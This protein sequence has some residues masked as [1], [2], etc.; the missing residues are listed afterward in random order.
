MSHYH[1]LHYKH[2]CITYIN[3]VISIVLVPLPLYFGNG[4]LNV[5]VKSQ[6]T[7]RLS[8][9]VNLQMEDCIALELRRSVVVE[10]VICCEQFHNGQL[11]PDV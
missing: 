11:R 9:N 10:V 4:C 7:E 3:A 5:P 2:Q 8:S 6:L 1:Q